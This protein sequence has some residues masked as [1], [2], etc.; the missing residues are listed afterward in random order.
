MSAVRSRNTSRKPSSYLKILRMRRSIKKASTRRC[1]SSTLRKP[2]CSSKAARRSTAVRC[3]TDRARTPRSCQSHVHSRCAVQVEYLHRL[4]YGVLES[5]ATRRAAS[6]D[7][8]D[9]D[10]AAIDAEG[11]DGDD[12]DEMDREEAPFLLLDDLRIDEGKNIDLPSAQ[13]ALTGRSSL[14]ARGKERSTRAVYPLIAALLREEAGGDTFH[15]SGAGCVLHESGALLMRAGLGMDRARGGPVVNF[16]TSERGDVFAAEDD[17]SGRVTWRSN[18]RRLLAMPLITLVARAPCRSDSGDTFMAS[19]VDRAPMSPATPHAP[20]GGD[21]ARLASAAADD[22]LSGTAP[23]SPWP[24]RG[25]E[26]ADVIA[27]AT[28]APASAARARDPVT[29]LPLAEDEASSEPEDDFFSELDP[30]DAGTHAC[31][32]CR[33]GKTWRAPRPVPTTCNA[34]FGS[35]GSDAPEVTTRGFMSHM[36]VQS[37]LAPPPRSRARPPCLPALSHPFCSYAALI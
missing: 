33:P 4:A 5:L 10:A 12:G 3:A 37:T 1:S 8:A 23:M 21:E 32:P 31:R 26:S 20:L 2:G 28:V 14:S 22:A 24:T 36:P 29:P 25:D 6:T 35:I 18:P 30:Y 15:V 7:A 19:D 9:G 11:A 13:G 16:G 27:A 17:D 34:I